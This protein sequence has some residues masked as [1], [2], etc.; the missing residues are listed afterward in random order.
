[1]ISST[2]PK[3]RGATITSFQAL[4]CSDEFLRIVLASADMK[5][6]HS[7]EICS[8][9]HLRNEPISNSACLN[10][11]RLKRRRRRYV[12]FPIALKKTLSRCL[13]VFRPTKTLK[14]STS[15]ATTTATTTTTSTTLKI[16]RQ[17][18][19]CGCC[20]SRFKTLSCHK[21]NPNKTPRRQSR[22]PTGSGAATSTSSLNSPPQIFTLK[23]PPAPWLPI[24]FSSSTAAGFS[25]CFFSWLI[26]GNLKCT[27]NP[28]ERA[29]AS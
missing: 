14:T 29:I 21:T 18:R 4:F 2:L 9:G 15:T 6:S 7:E 23:H 10:R 26:G 17:I 8:S 16:L 11:F 28:P 5:M 1:M 3:I 27:D 25:K 13:F 20:C 24:Y 22:P 19:R 12:W